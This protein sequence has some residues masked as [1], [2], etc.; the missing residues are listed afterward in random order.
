MLPKAFIEELNG[1]NSAI[2]DGLFEALTS[3]QPSVSIRVNNHKKVSLPLSMSRVKWCENGAYLNSRELFTFDPAM[4]QGLYYVQDA[5]SMIISYIIKQLTRGVD[6]PLCYL[7][8][9]AAPGGKTTAAIDS[10]PTGSLVVANE[11]VPGRAMVLTENV[12]KWGYPSVIDSNS[13]TSKFKKLK[14]FFDIV[15]TDVPC[16]GEG[17]FRK[18]PDAVAQWS[19]TLVKECV[20]RQK[21]IL[22]NLWGSLRCGG[23]LIYSTCT[24][25]RHENEDMVDYLVS[26]YGAETVD[27]DVIQN[28]GIEKGLLENLHTYRFMPHKVNG[29]GL[30]VAVLR[31]IG[32]NDSGEKKIKDRRKNIEKTNKIDKKLF[33]W[34]NNTELEFKNDKDSI[35]AIP[36]M[37]DKQIAELH[38]ALN[39]LHY[40]LPIATIKG[41]DI[42]PSHSLAM[43]T[44]LN[45][46]AFPVVDID[47]KQA[48]SYLR[49][50]TLT[51]N[52]APR[53][54]V[55]LTYRLHP[56][57]FVKN[58][59]NRANNLY[60]QQWRIL[61]T[62][63]PDKEITIV[64]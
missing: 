13:D 28:C 3:T 20:D 25:N 5:S 39:I 27:I 37:W 52:D 49:R 50:E 43:S 53:G 2:F 1:Y 29:E 33:N 21:M 38:S 18:D 59:G 24:F 36:K 45:V 47:Y 16:S 31:K 11:Y 15:A 61:S 42:I 63:V 40:G 30:F 58:L 55:L 10:L 51:L 8:A 6:K 4:H 46:E 57:G 60:P 26:E 54:F 7:D 12:I 34:V 44:L 14:S 23:Y 19:P 22:D 64:D 35:V 9:C 62:H 48:I 41:K 32:G 17:M 56:L